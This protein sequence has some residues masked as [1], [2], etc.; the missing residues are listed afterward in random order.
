MILNEEQIIE[1]CIRKNRRARKELYEQ[2]HRPMLGVCLRYSSSKDEAED[3]MLMGFMNIFKKIESF[4]NKGSFI[5]WMKRIMVNTAI[6]N[7]RKNKKHYKHSDIADFEEEPT[8]SVEFPDNLAVKDILAMVQSLPQGYK[9]VF[10]LFA[11]EGYSH[12]EIAEMLNVSV[13]T[14][15]TQL[16]HARK[17]LQRELEKQKV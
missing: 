3:I 6:D 16:F 9:I 2:Y 11:I 14:S 17:F 1:G 7:Y 5:G 12:L 13:N 4:S 15:K 8:L 10:N